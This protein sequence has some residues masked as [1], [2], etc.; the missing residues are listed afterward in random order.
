MAIL[1][2]KKYLQKKVDIYISL[3]KVHSINK[4]IRIKKFLNKLMLEKQI[5]FEQAMFVANGEKKK[6]G[7]I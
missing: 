4:K 3:K 5:K 2:A 1:L 7:G 6:K